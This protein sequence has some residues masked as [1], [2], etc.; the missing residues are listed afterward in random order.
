M[1]YKAPPAIVKELAPREFSKLQYR[2]RPSLLETCLPFIDI[3]FGFE[4]SFL[5]AH[6]AKIRFRL[7]SKETKN[8]LT[9]ALRS[10]FNPATLEEEDRWDYYPNMGRKVVFREGELQHAIYQAAMQLRGDETE[11]DEGGRESESSSDLGYFI[12]DPAYIDSSSDDFD[13][14]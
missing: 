6:G 12:P 11:S 9:F 4:V 3:P 5:P 14:P 1:D 7:R 10:Q 8:E 13:L 2:K